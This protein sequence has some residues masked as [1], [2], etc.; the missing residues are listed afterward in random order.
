MTAAVGFSE[1]QPSPVPQ[2]EAL[3]TGRGV[4]S[5]STNI[6]PQKQHPRSRISNH[7]CYKRYRDGAMQGAWSG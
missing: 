7:R 2:P 3:G 6:S 5:R 4:F 1:V